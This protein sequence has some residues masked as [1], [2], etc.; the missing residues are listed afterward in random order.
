MRRLD[1]ADARRGL[2]ASIVLNAPQALRLRCACSS[3][4]PSASGHFP[5]WASESAVSRY[6]SRRPDGTGTTPDTLA[7]QAT[8][9]KLCVRQ[10]VVGAGLAAMRREA[11]LGA[12]QIF[13]LR[14]A[15]RARSAAPPSE[16]HRSLG[17]L[18]IKRVLGSGGDGRSAVK[19]LPAARGGTRA[20]A[21]AVGSQHLTSAWSTD[22]GMQQTRALASQRGHGGRPRRSNLPTLQC[23]RAARALHGDVSAREHH[24]PAHVAHARADVASQRRCGSGGDGMHAAHGSRPPQRPAGTGLGVRR[25]R[26]AGGRAR[27]RARRASERVRGVH[28][29]L[30]RLM[31]GRPCGSRARL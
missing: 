7:S 1:T 29:Q 6:R 30:R 21:D 28:P 2:R 15:S 4:R 13:P 16:L 10:R 23:L 11:L 20:S 9:D 18:Q 26:P 3:E 12:Q 5:A 31:P 19:R 14:R 22:L 27:A 25:T 8:S 24:K 17:A